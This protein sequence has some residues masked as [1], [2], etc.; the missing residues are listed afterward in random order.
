M[1]QG[2]DPRHHRGQPYGRV[3]TQNR[4]GAREDRRQEV[5]VRERERERVFEYLEE[6]EEEENNA[7]KSKR[8]APQE[9]ASSSTPAEQLGEVQ[10]STGEVPIATDLAAQMAA[11]E[12]ARKL[13]EESGDSQGEKK[14]KNE[15]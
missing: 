14:A 6:E 9:A 1:M 13:E 4:R 15:E 2:R 12:A 5:G 7:K 8:G 11:P 10:R 3:P